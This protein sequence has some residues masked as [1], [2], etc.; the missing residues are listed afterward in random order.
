MAGIGIRCFGKVQGVFFRASTKSVADD[1][2]LR[3]WVRNEADGSVLIHAEGDS[4]KLSSLLSWA[5]E[6]SE[7]SQ[8]TEVR[9]WEEE[10]EGLESFEIRRD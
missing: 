10:E 6:G 2:G 5:N 1:L 4:K 8:V 3:G 7:Y 9:H